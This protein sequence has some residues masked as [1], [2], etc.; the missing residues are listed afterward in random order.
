MKHRVAGTLVQDVLKNSGD[1]LFKD[2]QPIKDYQEYMY[3]DTHYPPH[4]YSN[5]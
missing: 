4:V 1:S 3:V 2:T 5:S